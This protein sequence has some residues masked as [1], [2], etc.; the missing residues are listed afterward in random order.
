V[1]RFFESDSLAIGL[2]S[3]MKPSEMQL[4]RYCFVLFLDAYM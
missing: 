3:I 1:R 4:R 2:G